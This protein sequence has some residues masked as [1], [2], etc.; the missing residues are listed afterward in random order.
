MGT[1]LSGF[2]ILVI[3]DEALLR[4]RLIAHLQALGA[5]AEGA[6]TL[7]AARHKLSDR[8]FDFILL[9][10]H[11]PDGM[12]LDLMREKIIPEETGVVVMTAQ[13][14]VEGDGGD[15]ALVDALLDRVGH[16][17]NALIAVVCWAA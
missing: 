16:V 4:R 3:D 8:T 2:S 11:L 12:G 1:R 6:E 10:I 9:D 17:G 5:D 14:G 7:E 13:G 15:E